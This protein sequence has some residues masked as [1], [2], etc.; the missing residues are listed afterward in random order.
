MSPKR[1]YQWIKREGKKWQKEGFSRYFGQAVSLFSRGVAR[2][3]SSQIRKI[4]CKVGGNAGSQRRRLQRFVA[5]EINLSQFFTVWTRSVIKQIPKKERL[6]FSVDEVKLEDR[7]GVMVVG[8]AYKSR[9][10]PLAW[11]VYRANDKESYPE[12]GQVEMIL[13]LLEAVKKGVPARRKGLVLAD[14]GIGTSSEL[15]KGVNNLGWHYL[16]RVTKRS[17]LVLADGQVI[18]PVEQVKQAG[19]SYE[20]KGLIFSTQGRVPS[21][22]RVLWG[23]KAQEPWVLVTNDPR[24]DGWEYAQRM[25]QEESFRDLKSYGWQLE[26]N[27]FDDPARLARLW[28]ILVVTYVWL[29]LW[30]DALERQGL[31][32]PRTLRPDGSLVRRWSLFREGLHAF[33]EHF[34]PL[35]L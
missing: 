6:I 33:E 10:L 11:R 3:K 22:V 16:F 5:R 13:E 25:W 28:I 30:G 26:D 14:R 24:L 17:T 9:C 7:F 31:T 12:E 21:E 32:Q 18:K 34:C 15:M 19:Q 20:A 2:S 23:D 4:A 35:R 8:L 29:I 27:R 1:V